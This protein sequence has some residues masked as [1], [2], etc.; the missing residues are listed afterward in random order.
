MDTLK[1]GY[2]LL[3]FR[4]WVYEPFTKTLKIMFKSTN[5]YNSYV[6]DPLSPFIILVNNFI[7]LNNLL[8]ELTN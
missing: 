7:N 3:I 2:S 8:I 5:I 1:C 4:L 6:R